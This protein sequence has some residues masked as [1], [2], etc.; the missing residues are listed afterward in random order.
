MIRVLGIDPGLNGAVAILDLH[1]DGAL[2]HLT[3]VHVTPTLIVTIRKR[4]RREYDVPGMWRLLADAI[5]P[6][7]VRV[8]LVALEHQGPRPREGVVSSFRTGLGFGLWRALIVAAQVPLAIVAPQSWRR[9]YGLVSGGKQ[10]SIRCALERFPTYPVALTRHD[11]AA[12][13]TLIAGFA[14]RRRVLPDLPPADLTPAATWPAPTDTD[15]DQLPT[16]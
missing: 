11:G 14:A 2:L 5:A 1:Q 9:E 6:A 3:S 7:A 8:A 15:P 12:D 16:G 10:A 4:T 13:A